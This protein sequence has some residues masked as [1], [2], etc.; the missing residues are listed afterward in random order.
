MK[1]KKKYLVDVD[2]LFSLL[3]CMKK[4][5]PQYSNVIDEFEFLVYDIRFREVD[6][7]TYKRLERAGLW[8]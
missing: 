6:N 8:L 1:E 5:H 2:E 4:T 3:G 7:A